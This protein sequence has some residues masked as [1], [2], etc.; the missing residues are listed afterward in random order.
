MAIYKVYKIKE[1]SRNFN[2]CVIFL[3]NY[4]ANTIVTKEDYEYLANQNIY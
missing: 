4:C 3:Y 1:K 2:T